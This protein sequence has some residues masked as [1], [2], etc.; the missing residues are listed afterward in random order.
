MNYP[1][2]LLHHLQTLDSLIDSRSLNSFIDKLW[3]I[4]IELENLGNDEF[5]TVDQAKM[6]LGMPRKSLPTIE[7]DE[8]LVYMGRALLEHE[9][10]VEKLDKEISGQLNVGELAHLKRDREN[11]LKLIYQ[12]NFV[13]DW[14][15]DDPVPNSANP[16]IRVIK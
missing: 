16:L 12:Y 13:M 3:D 2:F 14:F 15:E 1:A 11:L 8:I 7:V 4:Q 6:I 10:S 9:A 5:V